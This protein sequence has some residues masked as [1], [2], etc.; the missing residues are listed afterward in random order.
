MTFD[1]A[2][3]SGYVVPISQ[4]EH[5]LT[6]LVNEKLLNG[7]GGGGGLDGHGARGQVP[8]QGHLPEAQG[9]AEA[10]LGQHLGRR[11]SEN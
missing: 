3:M 8:P 10:L 1:K 7:V 9:H 2:S 11:R 5:H 6:C 4:I